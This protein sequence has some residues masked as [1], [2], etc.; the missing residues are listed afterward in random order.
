VNRSLKIALCASLPV[1]AATACTDFLTGG[2]L[3]NDP[4][5]SLE[6][7]A[8]NLFNG[9]Q[10]TTFLI[11]TADFART[12]AMWMGQMAGTG[13]QYLNNGRY[14]ID[15][16]TH[17]GDFEFIYNQGGLT[18]IRKVQVLAKASNDSLFWGIAQVYEALNMGSAASI[19]GDLPYSEASNPEFP[20]PALDLQEDI[21]A[22]VQA[23]LDSAIVNIAGAGVGPQNDLNYGADPDAWTELAY[24]LKAR[25]YLHWVEAQLAGRAT[26]GVAC[27]GA[28]TCIAKANAAALNGIS[29]AANDFKTRHT[30]AIGEENVWYQFVVVQRPGYINAGKFLVDLLTARNDPRLEEYF[31]PGSSAG[32]TITGTTSGTPTTPSFAQVNEDTR[33]RPDFDQPLVTYD[34]NRLILAETEYYLGSAAQIISARNLVNEVRADAGYTT[35][36]PV[37]T[38]GQALLDE[39]MNEKYIALFQNIEVWNDYKRTCRPRIPVNGASGETEIPGRLYYGV[40][41]RQ[42]NP[43]IPDVAAQSANNRNENDP[44][45]CP[46]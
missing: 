15:E 44:N 32:T 24:T 25:Y 13:Q 37:T 9:V 20:T 21:Y 33:L 1:L 27:G 8:E 26:H 4:N 7:S 2:E 5:R 31:Q 18:D 42:T 16:T 41:E 19:W 39:I 3:D 46:P 12:A 14:D 43:N 35:Q 23:K 29:S 11:W 36:V 17:D 22:T 40:Q 28:G 38:V 6:A 34:E 45:A 10:A 30:V